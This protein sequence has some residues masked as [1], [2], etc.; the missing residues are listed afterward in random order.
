VVY[1]TIILYYCAIISKD[2]DTACVSV[3]PIL[4]CPFGFIKRL[5]IR[6]EQCKKK[7]HYLQ[8]KIEI[9][10]KQNEIITARTTI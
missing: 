5:F 1:V 7:N 6:W 4:D 3:L 10:S 9:K 8:N 2:N